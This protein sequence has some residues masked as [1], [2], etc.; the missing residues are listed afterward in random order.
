VFGNDAK[1]LAAIEARLDWLTKCVVIL[2]QKIAAF[3]K[4]DL[5]PAPEE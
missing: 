3:F 5:P 1:K 4:I 2:V